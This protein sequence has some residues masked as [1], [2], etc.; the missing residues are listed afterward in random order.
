MNATLTRMEAARIAAVWQRTDT[1][2]TVKLPG[3]R[4][5]FTPLDRYRL[6]L[7]AGN[8][9]EVVKVSDIA[10]ATVGEGQ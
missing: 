10:A 3:G 2:A 1:G 9:D 8:I 5:W 7:H 4:V 6:R